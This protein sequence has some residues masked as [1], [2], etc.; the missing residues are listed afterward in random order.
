MLTRYADIIV[1]YAISLILMCLFTLLIFYSPLLANLIAPF[2]MFAPLVGVIMANKLITKRKLSDFGIKI[3]IISPKLIVLALA[4]PFMVLF[5]SILISAPFFKIDLSMQAFFSQLK[6]VSEE[7]NIP[8]EVL[9]YA[10]IAQLIIAPLFNMIFAFGEE[11]GWRGFLFQRLLEETDMNKALIITGILWGIWHW[12]LIFA[13]GYNYRIPG[14]EIPSIEIRI[15]G[16]FLFLIF[17]I[18]F[19][20]FLVWLRL[21]G[22]SVLMPS[23]AHGAVNAYLG[24]GSF[25]ILTNNR[26]IGY[27][28]G[29][30]PIISI[31]LLTL[32][33]YILISK[34]YSK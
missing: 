16:A 13:I 3:G 21:E 17:T 8:F 28:A 34:K 12:P 31:V 27:P 25:I 14:E 30:I 24:F 1:F 22:K 7:Y 23:L 29:I 18:A 2:V 20:I 9:L 5:V 10:Q 11:S 32:P 19:G 15:A 4:Y 26:L 6:K 33:F